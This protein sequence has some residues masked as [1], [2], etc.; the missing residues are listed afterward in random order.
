MGLEILHL[1]KPGFTAVQME[2]ILIGIERRYLI[3]IMMHTHHELVA[4]YGLRGCHFSTEL[5]ENRDYSL[6]PE[7]CSTSCHSVAELEQVWADFEYCFISPVFNSI[8]KPD[9]QAGID[10][11]GLTKTLTSLPTKIVALGGIDYRTLPKVPGQCWGAAVLGAVWREA[12]MSRRLD[13]FQ[14]LQKIADKL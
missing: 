13:S 3:R 5:R 11:N 7:R 10:R 14:Q 8:S 4:K 6:L 2:R 12:K 9:Y 1:R